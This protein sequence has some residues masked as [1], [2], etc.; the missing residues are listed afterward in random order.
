MWPKVRIS[1]QLTIDRR[2]ASLFVLALS[3]LAACG[4]AGALDGLPQGREGRVTAVL[5]GDVIQLDGKEPVKLAGISAP[6]GEEPYA[7]MSRQTLQNLIGGRQVTLFFGGAR[8]DRFGRTLAQVEDADSRRWIEGAMLDAGAA[9]V[10]TYP[11]D[12]IPAKAMLIREAAARRA[13]R[14]LWTIP[15]YQVRLPDEVGRD[16]EGF[17]VVEGRA[18]RVGEGRESLYV[19]FSNDWRNT[20]SLVIPREALRA[21]RTAGVDPFDLQGRMIRVRG[22]VTGGRL[23]VNHPEQ[24]EVLAG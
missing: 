1:T 20:V 21:L 22:I 11:E 18:K 12:R 17:M 15:E 23:L 16:D 9:R 19:D 2:L 10:R 3:L 6:R 13:D 7:A 24:I 8:K 4:D 14:G 5:A